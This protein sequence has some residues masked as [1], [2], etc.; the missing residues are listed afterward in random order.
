MEKIPPKVAANQKQC[1]LL[2][3][4]LYAHHFFL[5]NEIEY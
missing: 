1:I 5:K 3:A 4:N 2:K